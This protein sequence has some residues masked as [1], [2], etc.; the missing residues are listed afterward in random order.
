[1]HQRGVSPRL[2]LVLLHNHL[3]GAILPP[4][5]EVL[6]AADLLDLG[7]L[8]P[9]FAVAEERVVGLADVVPVEDAR[10]L[11]RGAHGGLHLDVKVCDARGFVDVLGDDELEAGFG[12]ALAHD[13]WDTLDGEDGL[14]AVGEG[15]V[16]YV[17][18][19]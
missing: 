19:P 15:F 4:L 1:M 9:G 12:D 2:H 14:V 7:E 6:I 18:R 13:P 5:G 11:L 16:L 3:R 17:F 10:F 8:A